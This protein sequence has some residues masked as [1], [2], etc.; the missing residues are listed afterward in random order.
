MLP[1]R[2]MPADRRRVLRERR[3]GEEKGLAAQAVL[4]RPVPLERCGQLPVF[5]IARDAAVV[6]HPGIERV[7][8]PGRVPRELVGDG[9]RDQRDA[10]A[11]VDF[12]DA[13]EVERPGQGDDGGLQV[14]LHA[15]PP[16]MSSRGSTRCLTAFPGVAVSERSAEAELMRIVPPAIPCF[17]PR[18]ATA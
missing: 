18:R 13:D 10:L 9:G 14:D 16:A 1:A 7:V 8:D 4:L 12:V 6:E 17:R 2:V 5:A 11:V 15:A 3:A